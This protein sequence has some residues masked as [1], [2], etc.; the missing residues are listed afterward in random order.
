MVIYCEIM[1]KYSLNCVYSLHIK[2]VQNIHTFFAN[3]PI[4]CTAAVFVLTTR[5]MLPPNSPL[6]NHWNVCGGI[7]LIKTR[8]IINRRT[9]E[10]SSALTDT[11]TLYKCLGR[12]QHS[13]KL[14]FKVSDGYLTFSEE[15]YVAK[16]NAAI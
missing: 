9:H 5:T 4:S 2:S 10:N 14:I 16:H 1:L 12:G 3:L 7:M 13:V 6:T 15:I 8:A 11:K